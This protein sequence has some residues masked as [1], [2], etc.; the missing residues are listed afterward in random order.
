MTIAPR[1]KK[2]PTTG[3]TRKITAIER[4]AWHES[5]HAV[6]SSAI[7]DTP[8]HLSIRVE[9]ISLGRNW[10]KMAARP[11]TLVQVYLAGFAAEHL[12]TG[13]RSRHLNTEVGFGI[14][15]EAYPAFEAAFTES[16]HRDGHAAVQQLLRMGI[17]AKTEE[18][19]HEIDR[20]YVI[21]RESL[22]AVW[23]AVENLARALLEHEEMDRE[24]VEAVLG[25][26]PIFER[27]LAVQQ[28]HGF[29][30]PSAGEATR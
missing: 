4:T 14:L 2:T 5:G 23:P 29:L 1:K 6:L 15:A 28:A 24:G 17:P 27:V 25:D 11:S 10:M 8:N 12:V 21:T 19:Q 30:L 7:N 3:G 22:S 20:Y 13:R 18:I 9:G 16:G 26:F